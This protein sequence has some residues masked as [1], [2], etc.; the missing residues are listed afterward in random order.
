MCCKVSLFNTAA[1]WPDIMYLLA[2]ATWL[3]YGFALRFAA[4]SDPQ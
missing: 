4:Q 1:F 3:G 2:A